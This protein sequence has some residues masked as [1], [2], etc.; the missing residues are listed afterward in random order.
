ML[1]LLVVWLLSALALMLVA[2]LLPGVHIK[3]YQSALIAA[4]IL[5]LINAVLRPLLAFITFPLTVLTLGLFYLVL[6][7]LLFWLAGSISR[8]FKVD[9]FWAGVFGVIL[10]SV[11]NWALSSVVPFTPN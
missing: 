4:V 9:G 8:G 1:E 3:N 11:I 5:G 7:G 6:N 10:Y 2:Y